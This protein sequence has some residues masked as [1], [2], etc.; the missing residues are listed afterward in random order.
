MIA[1]LLLASCAE[2]KAPPVESSPEPQTS[3]PT[4]PPIPEECNGLDD[5]GDGEID[6]DLSCPDGDCSLELP[7]GGPVPIVGLCAL[8]L[9]SPGQFGP[10]EAP[11]LGQLTDDNR[12]GT[13]GP[14][15]IADLVS[16]ND[17][18][19]GFEVISGDGLRHFSLPVS[20]RG[21]VLLLDAEGDGE[22]EIYVMEAVSFDGSRE[23]E[24]WSADGNQ[25]WVSPRLDG[26]GEEG[27]SSID[28]VPTAGD[29]DHDGIVELVFGEWI[30]DSITGELVRQLEAGPIGPLTHATVLADLEGDGTTEILLGRSVYGDSATPLWTADMEGVVMPMAIDLDE[31]PALEVVLVGSGEIRAYDPDGEPLW[32]I[33]PI[34]KSAMGA[35]PCA[36]DFDGDGELELGVPLDTRLVVLEGDG[37]PLW[38]AALFEPGAC[39]AADL[40]GD[41]SA[42]LVVAGF[43]GMWILEG[44]TGNVVFHDPGVSG[45]SAPVIV[46]FDGDN[47]AEIIVA[48]ADFSPGGALEGYRIYDS[49]LWPGV[50]PQWSMSDFSDERLSPD[51]QVTPRTTGLT[52]A[53]TVTSPG[54]PGP[55]PLLEVELHDMCTTSCEPDG[56]VRLSVIVQNLGAVDAEAGLSLQVFSRT[57]TEVTLVAEVP[58]PAIPSGTA[59]DA[60]PVELAPVAGPDEL[61]VELT[62]DHQCL[63][64]RVLQEP[65]E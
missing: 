62:G 50:G 24:R 5:D 21:H 9:P 1:T 37:T 44:G 57:E 60:I 48:S 18:Y 3:T 63:A 53:R 12:D 61:F 6:E 19:Q 14:G 45:E 41:G 23:V 49:P 20:G 39:S 40:D 25:I 42:E 43:D 11:S 35:P 36:A 26:L 47:K 30:L 31:D 46:D 32:Q 28:G 22:N 17:G 29:L 13:V 15:D 52:H 33:G 2:D 7:A 10:S 34:P 16:T 58:L 27:W 64:S 4:T 55:S 65:C 54:Q 56:Q 59:L 51:G 38:E 8:D